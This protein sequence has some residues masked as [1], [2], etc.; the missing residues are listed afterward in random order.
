MI[1]WQ[2]LKNYTLSLLRFLFAP[3]PGD[4]I[5]PTVVLPTPPKPAPVAPTVAPPVKL[6]P[7]PTPMPKTTPAAP[8]TIL[9]T[10][11]LAIQSREGYYG[12]GAL[13][14]YPKGTPA[15]INNNPGNLRCG[16]DNKANW[17]HLAKGQSNNFCVFPSYTVGY[18]A[19]KNEVTAAAS[20]QSA[21]YKADMVL[22]NPNYDPVHYVHAPLDQNFWPGFFQ[23]YSPSGD[24]NDPAS[25]ANEVAG[26]LGVN[27]QTFKIKQLLA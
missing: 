18:Q 10:F 19:L 5:M 2:T 12:P 15:F 6:T 8:T 9:D 27:A 20:G 4:I 24:N 26:K 1:P 7:K 25:Y 17:N 21:V 22:F 13:A 14:G 23:L 3:K 16:A 11:C